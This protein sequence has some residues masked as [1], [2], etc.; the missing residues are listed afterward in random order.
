MIELNCS[1]LIVGSVV[2]VAAM[3]VGSHRRSWRAVV[4]GF[5]LLLL[6]FLPWTG[7]VTL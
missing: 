3:A 7:F 2:G 1:I 4:A 6:A 5:G